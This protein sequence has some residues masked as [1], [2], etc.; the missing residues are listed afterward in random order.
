[1]TDVALSQ[2]LDGAV[3]LAQTGQKGEAEQQLRQLVAEGARL[4]KA[5]MALGVLCGERGHLMERRLWLEQALRLQ[6]TAGEPPSLRLLLNLCVDA[7]EQGDLDRA[8]GF[9]EEALD[10]YP[11]ESEAHLHQ[12]RVLFARGE[13]QAAW[14]HLERACEGLRSRVADH[15]DDLAAWRLLGL[16][17][18]NAMRQDAAIEAYKRALALDPNHVPTLLAI[19]RQL[20]NRG[21][22]AEAMPWLMNAM[23]VDAWNAEVLFCN[24]LALKALGEIQQAIDL[25]RQVLEID[26]AM[27]DASILLAFSMCE[28]GLFGKALAVLREALVHSPD[29]MAC[30]LG[31]AVCLRYMGEFSRSLALQDKLLEEAPDAIGVFSSWMFSTS[32]CDLVPPQ[33]VLATARRFWASQGVEEA[34]STVASTAVP[35]PIGASSLGRPLRVGL[36]SADIGD[37]VVGR[38]L[39]PLLRHHDPNR[40]Q[41]ELI[42]MRRL[43]DSS[44]ERLFGLADG[45]LLLEG[46]PPDQARAAMRDRAYDLIVDTSGY[47]R[48]S[49]LPLLAERCAPLQAHYI[50]YHATTGL[51]TIDGFIGDGETAAPELQEQFSERLWRLPRPWLAYPIDTPFPKATP[52]MQTDRPVL[53][54]FCQVGKISDPTLAIW[55]ATLRRVPEAV[56]VLKDRGLQDEDMRRILEERLTAHGVSADRVMLLAPVEEWTD[57]VDYYNIIDV[58]LDTTPWSSATTGFEALGMGVPLVA[59]RGTAMA[60]RMSS[61]LVRALGRHE[62]IGET[63]EE[64]AES[65]ATLCADLTTLRQDKHVRQQVALASVLFDGADLCNS[66]QNLFQTVVEASVSST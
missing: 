22:V 54:C 63:A 38:F 56:L 24:A 66:V 29:N 42:S 15:P 30:R 50:G 51:A 37:H 16:A 6:H 49:G 60:A 2:R 62:W 31:E 55:A 32:I 44:T 18:T 41:L 25:F 8:R 35:S 53:G 20:L 40:C 46:L 36:L 52:L 11:L 19:S 57:H 12:S 47:T 45:H 13:S 21:S 33:N 9:G 28:Q 64:I 59:F 48:G 4:P 43:Y 27:A 26:P 3:Q 34:P 1:M 65:V 10:H 7:L 61:S 5:A 58:A 17:E 14:H 23:A 39:T